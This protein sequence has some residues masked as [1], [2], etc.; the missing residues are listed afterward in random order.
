MKVKERQLR[1]IG[2]ALLVQF[3]VIWALGFANYV[4]QLYNLDVLRASAILLVIGLLMMLSDYIKDMARQVV[5]D[6]Y[7]RAL[8]MIYFAAVYYIVYS[9]MMAYYRLGLGVS[10]DTATYM[11]SFASAALYRRLFDSFAVPTFFYNHA[12]P[13]L[14]LVYPLYLTYPGIPTLMTIQTA[15]ATLPTIPL[16][17]LGLKLFG[18]RR[19]ALLT[20]LAYLLFPW[21]TTYLV[22]PFEVVILTAPFFALALYSL[23]TGNRLGYWLSL[24]LM[25]TTIEFSPI[26]GFFIG[27]YI[28]ATKLDWLKAKGRVVL[29]IETLAYSLAWL[30]GDFLLVYYFSHGSINIFQ[31]VW[32]SALSGPLISITDSIGNAIFHFTTHTSPSS[33][34]SHQAALSLSSVLESLVN[35]VRVG[36]QTKIQSTVFLMMP[37]LF[38][39][40]MEPQNLLLL[41]W[42]YVMW[43]TPWGFYYVIWI[44]YTALVAPAVIVPAIWAL[45]K[46]SPRI[47]RALLVTVFIAVTISTLLLN[48][49][50]PL[51]ALY[52][53]GPMPNPLQPAAT[54]YDLALIQLNNYVPPNA[55]V[56]VPATAVPWF[57]L[58]RYGW[59]DH[60]VPF[61]GPNG[62]TKYEVYSPLVLTGYPY[63]P[64]FNNYLPYVFNDGAWLLVGP[65][66]R[67]YSFNYTTTV[68]LLPLTPG[69][70]QYS[71]ATLP[72]GPL[73]VNLSINYVP[74]QDIEYVTSNLSW[75]LQQPQSG[76][77]GTLP[78]Y[79]TVSNSNDYII[80]P[81]T[82]NETTTIEALTIFGSGA[83]NLVSGEVMISSSEVPALKP[84]VLWSTGFGEPWWCSPHSWATPI[85]VEPN[86]TLKPGTYYVIVN[87]PTNPWQ[88][89][90]TYIPGAPKALLYN[91][92]GL[93]QLNC[94]MNLIAV[95]NRPAEVANANAGVS[96]SLIIQNSTAVALNK[97]V[98]LVAQR[99]FELPLT[100]WANL[101]GS[102]YQE[103]LAVS[104]NG[105]SGLPLPGELSVTISDYMP[106]DSPPIPLIKLHSL[107][108]TATETLL[109]ITP[110][111]HQ[112]S[113]AF[114][115]EGPV[116]VSVDVNY[117]PLQTIEYVTSDLP[118][119]LQQPQSGICGTLPGY[120]ALLDS[121]EYLVQPVTVNETVTVESL[122]VFGSGPS[123]LVS[124]Q[125]VISRSPVP[126]NKGGYLWSTGFGEPWWCSPHGWATPIVTSPKA[127]LEPGTYYVILHMPTTPWQ[128]LCTYIPGAPKA[129]VYNGS[130]LVKQLNCTMNLIM[131]TNR[132]ASSTNMSSNITVSLLG[133]TITIS[134][135]RPAQQALTFE[136]NVTQRAAWETLVVNV[137]EAIPGNLTIRVNTY[138]L[139]EYPPIRVPWYLVPAYGNIPTYALFALAIAFL[140]AR[141]RGSELSRISGAEGKS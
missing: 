63:Y 126:T 60:G 91:G 61:F 139:G 133:R 67:P 120:F 8:I 26:L 104:V 16:Y 130:A 30:F 27:L 79:F 94:T 49:L 45:R 136:A 19:Y 114:L 12:S 55:S 123:N 92:T 70:H 75:L 73:T 18:D 83:S 97:T 56:S 125:V 50:S 131:V 77:C 113:L 106:A 76:I 57:S 40:L 65:F 115:P 84:K 90:C 88:V 122:V 112:Y 95:T 62:Y 41:P 129:L 99:P 72:G 96:I 109:P 105:G 110:G 13:I 107:N 82:I 32:G 119:V 66:Q 124:G 44:Y 81:I 3:Y 134:P 36:L 33:S 48:G 118:Q 141:K 5:A 108:Y 28:L 140:A 31:N 25:M 78:G 2:A 93:K 6:K 29:S 85:S 1:L 20:A 128:A 58:T 23:Y 135:Q 7:F 51:S 52:F 89:V 38:L 10:L 15:L 111:S 11:Q 21:V 68:T 138:V 103:A 74:L 46:F 47:R 34:S 9:V 137:S 132:P 71:V 127:K 17:K 86:L 102:S 43:Q 4:P 39:N 37:T 69:Q 54:P 35:N 24:T 22:G 87:M 64:N 59:N 98:T 100:Y 117:T 80:Q 53:H 42:L 121:S 116:K 101:T 14:F